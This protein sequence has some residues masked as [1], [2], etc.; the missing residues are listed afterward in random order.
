MFFTLLVLLFAAETNF[1][2]TTEDEPSGP[3]TA[4]FENF[5]DLQPPN[6]PENWSAIVQATSVWANLETTTTNT[7][8][9]EPNHVRFSNG[10]DPSPTM[11]LIT[12]EVTNFQQNW[13]TFWARAGHVTE[14]EQLIVGYMSDPDNSDTFVPT[15]TVSV[16][17]DVYDKFFFGFDFLNPA[18][19]YHLAIKFLPASTNRTVYL[20][21]VAWEETPDGPQIKVE[22]DSGDFGMVDLGVAKEMEIVI[23]NSGI[24]VLT[25]EQGDITITGADASSFMFAELPTFPIELSMLEEKALKLHFLPVS[26]GEKNAQMEIVSNADVS[27]YIYSL[28][29]YGLGVVSEFFEDFDD[30]PAPDLPPT[31]SIIEETTTGS[32]QVVDVTSPHSDPYHVRMQTSNDGN[33]MLMMASRKVTDFED[34]WLRFYAKMSSAAHESELIIGYSA[35]RYDPDNFVAVD[36]MIVSGNNYELR[37]FTFSEVLEND[38]EYSIV[39]KFAPETTF[40]NLFLDDILWGTAPTET[41]VLIDP[42]HVDFGLQQV[43]E[44]SEEFIFTVTND[45]VLDFTVAPEDIQITGADADAFVLHNIDEPVELAMAESLSFGVIFSP[46]ALGVKNATVKVL[47]AEAQL[48]GISAD[49]DITEFPYFQDF[50]D[51]DT[52]DLPFGWDKIVDNPT[53]AAATV[54]TVTGFTPLSPPNHVR[55]FSNNNTE[56]NVMLI[57]PL[58]QGLDSKR[59]RFWA[60]CNLSS[61]V[62]DLIIGTMTDPGDADTFV[63]FQTITGGDELSNSYEQYIVVFDETVE[64]EAHIAFR[65]GGT[66]NF[67]RS[68]L[69]DDFLLEEIPTTPLLAVSP[70][71]HDFGKIQINTSSQAQEFVISNDGTD[72]LTLTPEDFAITGT[73]A[74]SF[75]LGSIPDEIN[76]A[77]FETETIEVFFV[78]QNL[79][80]KTAVLTIDDTDVDLGGVGIDASIAT[81]P[82]LEDFDSVEA[83][84]LIPGWTAIVD[85][86][87]LP[88]AVVQTLTSNNPN[89]EPNHVQLLSNNYE[90][91]TVMLISPPVL[92]MDIVEVS[93][94]AKCNLNSNV[95]DLIIGV[96]SDPSNTDSFTTVAVF[97]GGEDL[98]NDYQEYIVSLVDLDLEG[99]IAF[100]H[101]GTPNFNRSI[102]I[103]DVL[104]DYG[105]DVFTVNFSVEDPEGNPIEDAVVTLGEHTNEPGNYLFENIVAGAY[106]Y[107]IQADHFET[108]TV[109][110]MMIE[111]DETIQVTMSPVHY[112][113]TF[114]VDNIDGA[115]VDNAVITF[116]DHVNDPGDYVFDEITYGVYDF[117]VVADHYEV[118]DGHGI[119]VEGDMTIS[120]T[121][122]HKLYTVTFVPQDN[123]GNIIDDAVVTFDGFAMPAGAYIIEEV[124]YGSYEYTVSADHFET[125]HGT[126]LLVDGDIQVDVMLDHTLYTVTFAVADNDGNTLNDAIVT[127]DGITNAAGD[128]VFEGVVLG[129]Y[130]YSVEADHFETYEGFGLLVDENIQVDVMLD[131]TLYTVTFAVADNDGNTLND[132][133]VTF[134]GI[135]NAAGD[136]VFENVVFGTYDYTVEAE[137]YYD[138][139]GTVE[140]NEDMDVE[141]VMHA[142]P[143]TYA[144]TFNVDMTGAEDFDADNNS[145]FISGSFGGDIDWVVPGEN[146]DLKLTRIDDSMLFTITLMLEEGEYEYKYASDAFGDGWEGAEWPGTPNRQ[147]VVDGDVSV[148]DIWGVHP[149]EVSITEVITDLGMKVYPNP[150]YD[151]VNITSNQLIQEIRLFDL[152]GNLVYSNTVN[153]NQVRFGLNTFNDGMYIIQIVTDKGQAT[154]RLHILR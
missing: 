72:I 63:P 98:T 71:E 14:E 67:T 153:D 97:E 132:A 66:P 107:T 108:V 33:A 99:H 17:G 15:D 93:F 103:D 41:V 35:N 62:P 120:V 101:G 102:F 38:D 2:A 9:S 49:S 37:S 68:I 11:I 126:G 140:V 5:D 42:D 130:D 83:P 16:A 40:R 60:R 7:P 89:S 27:P 52:P 95:P 18:D 144:V 121:L 150:A 137:G 136:Y 134:D 55:I 113:V 87:D 28:S 88:S 74:G 8:H 34:N 133:I 70:A 21:D 24:G 57:T 104:F 31:W 117:S 20:D 73:D 86:P 81:L 80:E 50:D 143:V 91:A 152:L 118:Y 85:N 43:G 100:K 149:D 46:E 94:W 125:Y 124:L 123:D 111:A 128:Y 48:T 51:V 106:D 54:E 147:I 32:V 26:E 142:I 59:I 82:F 78:P 122:D 114:H 131:H 141:I 69:I 47:D 36:T 112:V 12:E 84:E 65:F 61:N 79:G 77:S 3:A 105:V 6:L 76:L 29:G 145:V 10:T 116:G 148:D 39:F 92:N 96:M 135:T 44:S 109:D 25:I 110:N 19:S 90:D 115:D 22:P 58:V 64:A 30:A 151:A 53:H 138:T 13:L 4:F 139:E 129:S 154:E 146:I 1:A 23:E 45:G 75:A 127:F 119:L 56:A